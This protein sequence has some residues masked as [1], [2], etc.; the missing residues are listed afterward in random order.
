M[1]Y[2]FTTKVDNVDN[3]LAADINGVQ[4]GITDVSASVPQ[5]YGTFFEPVPH[6]AITGVAGMFASTI[7]GVRTRVPMPFLVTAIKI[8]CNAIAGGGTVD[9]GI[10][11]QAAGTWTKVAGLSAAVTAAVG[12]MTL[13]LSAAYQMQPGIDYYIMVGPSAAGGTTFAR[14]QS[15]DS[16]MSGEDNTCISKVVYP[17]PAS[18]T[19]PSAAVNFFW[20][21]LVGS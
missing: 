20:T 21:R 4:Q 15:A 2:S 11:T 16:L 13:T 5:M 7:N 14:H 8:K 10:Y 19:T 12:V 6:W 18:F 17:C 9:A 1:P 3:V